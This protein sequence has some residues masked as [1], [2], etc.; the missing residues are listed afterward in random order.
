MTPEEFAKKM[1]EIFRKRD[2]EGRHSEA[3]K[4][5]CELLKSLGY[6]K[7][8]KIFEKSDKWYS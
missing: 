6:E 2:K 7:G 8:V 3:D 4:L 5:M 1:R